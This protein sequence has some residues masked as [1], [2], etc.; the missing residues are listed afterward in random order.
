[1]TKRCCKLVNDQFQTDVPHIY[2]AGDVISFPALAATSMEQ[3]RLASCAMFGKP[4][5]FTPHL[6]PYGVYTIPEISMVGRTERELTEAK[7]PYEM[8][9]ARYA[10]IAKGL[11]VGD[12]TGLLKILFHLDTHK[13]LGVHVIGESATEIIHIAQAVM[14]LDGSIEYFRDSVFNYPT[15]AEAYKIAALN[16]LNKL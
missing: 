15:F 7:I 10:E 1:L 16:G 5:T 4:G 2:A 13:V 12:Q 14:T 3:G 8:G 6:L 9:L 11:M